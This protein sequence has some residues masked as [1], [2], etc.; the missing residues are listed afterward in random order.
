MVDYPH[1]ERPRRILIRVGSVA[2]VLLVVWGSDVVP[3]LNKFSFVFQREIA[4]RADHFQDPC[5]P[6][7]EDF[8]IDIGRSHATRP[9][10][11]FVWSARGEGDPRPFA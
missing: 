5:G 10:S 6:L 8:R 11:F 7:C 2:L 9:G 3:V 1:L 4:K